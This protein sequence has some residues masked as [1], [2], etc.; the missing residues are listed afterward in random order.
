[1]PLLVEDGTGLA[2]ADAYVSVAYVDSYNDDFR[3]TAAWTAASTATKELA[4]RQATQ[5]VDSVYGGRWVGSPVL[6]EQ[7]LDWPRYDVYDQDGKY[8]ASDTLPTALLQATSEMAIRAVSES[9]LP[10]ID[11]NEGGNV[12]RYRVKVDVLEEE[13]EYVGAGNSPYKRYTLVNKLLRDI[14]IGSNSM[15]RG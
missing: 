8:I 14:L 15:E 11:A 10:D 12:K 6:Y 4:I 1:M 9:I 13:T 2:N 3:A 5:Y 7:A